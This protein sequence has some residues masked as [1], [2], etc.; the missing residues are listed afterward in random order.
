MHTFTHEGLT[1][2]YRDAGTGPA[3]VMLHNGGTSSTIWRHQIDALSDRHRVVAVDLPGFGA[4]PRPATAPRLS[5]MVDLI[6]ALIESEGLAPALLVGNCMGTNIA[7]ALARST[8]EVVTGILAINPLTEASFSAGRIGFLHRMERLAATP[9]RALRSASRRIRTPRQAGTATLRFQLGKLGIER[10]LHH[11]PELLA[12]QVRPDQLP[13]LVDVLDDMAAYGDLDR[14]GVP[15]GT[16]VWIVWGEQNRVL[17]RQ[18][19]E[20]LD[21]VMHAERVE[22][23]EGTGHLP[24]LEDPD[25]VTDLVEQLVER[26]SSATTERREASS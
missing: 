9:T 20:H 3:I 18:R 26:T 4:S 22:V 23:L 13:A 10:G 7:A 21:R 2:A 8:P 16:P 19:A 17:S 1:V 15:A 24:M 11:D 5:Q 25:V 14:Q 12:C 6:A